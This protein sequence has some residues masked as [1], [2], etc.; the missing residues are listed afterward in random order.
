MLENIITCWHL[1]LQSHRTCSHSPPSWLI[2]VYATWSTA[3]L[4]LNFSDTQSPKQ[5]KYKL[6]TTVQ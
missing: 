5:C 3:T 1:V 6:K 2:A 4:L